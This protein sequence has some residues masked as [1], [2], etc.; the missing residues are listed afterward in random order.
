MSQTMA[1][2][3]FVAKK[4]EIKTLKS[5]NHSGFSISSGSNYNFMFPLTSW[6]PN[7]ASGAYHALWWS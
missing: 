2:I 1:G 4:Q 7:S 6:Q 3:P 5:L